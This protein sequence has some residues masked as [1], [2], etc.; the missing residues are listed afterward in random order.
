MSLIKNLFYSVEGFELR[1]PR[2]SLPDSGITA[3]CGPSGSGKTTII[4]FYAAFY[5]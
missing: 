3:L 5:L 1:I 2:W 4:K